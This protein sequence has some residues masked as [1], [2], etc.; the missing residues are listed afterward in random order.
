M[1]AEQ[2]QGNSMDESGFTDSPTRKPLRKS[3]TEYLAPALLFAA[4]PI[5]VADYAWDK[6]VLVGAV[7]A[8]CG[9]GFFA[10]LVV[11]L[12]SVAVTWDHQ[13]VWITSGAFSWDRG[14]FGIKW[15]DLE[16]AS[17]ER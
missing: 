13:G 7:V 3:W 14:G 11:V 16:G 1:A 5:S 9:L 2:P 17:C 12:R 10:Y 15:R 8:G 4:L 6:S